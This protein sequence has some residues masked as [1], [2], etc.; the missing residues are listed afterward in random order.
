[1]K[2]GLE[3]HI[4]LKDHNPD[5]FHVSLGL[6][7]IRRRLKP[8]KFCAEPCPFKFNSLEDLYIII[9]RLENPNDL[10]NVDSLDQR[11]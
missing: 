9:K 11:G 8:G 3:P 7:N 4:K 10:L 1:M 6:A 5:Q 2:K